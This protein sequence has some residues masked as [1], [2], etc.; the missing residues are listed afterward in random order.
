MI[1][2]IHHNNNIPDQPPTLGQAVAWIDKLGGHLGRK[3]D[4]SPGFKTV[5]LGHQRVCDAEDFYNIFKQLQFGS[6]L[7]IGRRVTTSFSNIYFIIFTKRKPGPL[8]L[9]SGCIPRRMVQRQFMAK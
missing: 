6:G 9:K 1:L 2:L 3:S 4:W 8:P 7:A 5:W